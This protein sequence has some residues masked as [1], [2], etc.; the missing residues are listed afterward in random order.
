MISKVRQ[1]VA[2]PPS[3]T[4]SRRWLLLAL[5]AFVLVLLMRPPLPLVLWALPASVHC[6]QP[7]GTVWRGHCA[8]AWLQRAGGQEPIKIQLGW[9]VLPARLL[10]GRLAA[11]LHLARGDSVVDALVQRSW[12]SLEVLSLQGT[13]RLE[14]QLLPAVP[15]GWHGTAALQAVRLRLQGS[16]LMALE[17]RVRVAQ[18]RSLIGQP[19]DYGTVIFDWPPTPGGALKP[20]SVTDEGGP[21]AL[22][23]TLTLQS[24]G[25][26]QLDG[27]V[28]ARPPVAAALAAQLQLLGSA[29]ADQQQ[30]FSL[31]GLP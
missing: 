3:G 12:G 23:A 19:I 13:V 14:D 27:T 20:A 6:E 21:L 30:Q 31:A 10:R 28:A 18:L 24:T 17:G 8:Q 11:Q 7:S 22:K 16:A 29:A 2:T 5:M 9:Q 1:P 26:W 25:A 15:A 4:L